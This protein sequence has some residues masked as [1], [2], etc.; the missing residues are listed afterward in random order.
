LI[1]HM[2]KLMSCLFVLAFL[3][4][5][6]PLQAQ[7]EG[8]KGLFDKEAPAFQ[9]TMLPT[10]D[11]GVVMMVFYFTHS[12]A[13]SLEASVWI[14]DQ[15]PTFS[16]DGYQI[17]V[18]GLHEIRNRQEDT[19]LIRG[20]KPLHFY[21]IGVD[22]RT[23]KAF[24]S[25]FTSKPVKE[26]YRYEW[27]GNAKP[28]QIA[29]AK[30]GKEAATAKTPCQNPDITVQLEPSGYCG[31]SNY[32]AVQIVCTN[33]KGKNWEF[34]VEYR[35]GNNNWASLRADGL[36][37]PAQGNATRTEPLCALLPGAYQIRVSAREQYCPS[38]VFHYLGTQVTVGNDKANT[39]VTTEKSAVQTPKS[40]YPDT[41]AAQAKAVRYGN[42][43][44]GTIVLENNSPC[45][46]YEPF[47][48]VRYIH[49]GY[50]DINPAPVPLIPG[51]PA[52]FDIPLDAK[53][54]QRG[55]HT[56]Q[57]I[58]YIRPNA[59]SAGMPVGSFW[60]KA[61]NYE[62]LSVSDNTPG[63]VPKT[64]KVS[65][66]DA[67]PRKEVMQAK[68]AE[69]DA[70]FDQALLQQDIE[71]VNV[72]ASDPNC[73]QVQ[74]LQLVYLTA[75]ADKPAYVS[76]MNPR[77]CQADGCPYTVWAGKSPSQLRLLVEGSKRGVLVK[78]LL[79]ELTAE[80]TYIEVV[81]KSPNG[82]RKAGY[83]VGK[84][85]LY[86]Y[87][88]I[89][90]YSDELKPAAEQKPA[91]YDGLRGVKETVI[92]ANTS[93]SGTLTPNNKDPEAIPVY[94]APQLPVSDFN[95]CK[96]K[97]E[98]T[99]AGEQPVYVG[100]EL[101]IKYDYTDPEYRFSLYLLPDGA[102]E[103]VLAPGVEELQE[104]AQFKLNITRAHAGKYVVL[105]YNPA[106]NW[107]CLSTPLAQSLELKVLE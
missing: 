82:A 95:P 52:N 9:T 48:Q 36:N 50:R 6:M 76:W 33:C 31:E 26:G 90:A 20:L 2:K 66:Y 44:R 43:I 24:S 32:P 74:D 61:E 70:D 12:K 80:D 92:P 103:W 42:S 5:L 62:T 60:I 59:N 87:E 40:V 13:T 77:C 69:V 88:A 64:E 21:T 11:S 16:A 45:S 72:N 25:K 49:P 56:I 67:E 65:A 19:V 57:V 39:D 17:M 37:Q 8:L 10:A 75:A 55:I 99:I 58:T 85:P 71:L 53:D 51:V 30:P 7:N 81:V 96:Y 27:K 47:A 83:V 28:K 23:P 79:Q 68:P 18:K 54:L 78:E 41:C 94:Q 100:D 38:P 35:L 63:I 34:S 91:E 46:A 101:T 102:N 14:K 84:G 97:R 4:G 107:G 3:P 1:K 104:A 105:V 22:Y 29:E 86:G 73:N 98:T 89:M 15:G 106:K 93:L